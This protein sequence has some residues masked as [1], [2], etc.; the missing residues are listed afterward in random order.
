MNDTDNEEGNYSRK[1][2]DHLPPPL[3]IDELGWPA[4]LKQWNDAV[5][6]IRLQQMLRYGDI[7]MEDKK[8][9]YLW[10]QKRNIHIPKE[11]FDG[12]LNYP[13]ENENQRQAVEER[14]TVLTE[15]LLKMEAGY[16]DKDRSQY[17]KE[18][19]FELLFNHRRLFY[20]P[21]SLEQITGA[22]ARLNTPLP[23]SYKEFLLASNGFL[24]LNGRLLA[25][26]EIDWLK[27]RD[28]DTMETWWVEGGTPE[29][30]DYTDEEYVSG[31]DNLYGAADMTRVQYL[32]NCLQIGERIN[33]SSA[34]DS[35]WLLNPVTQPILGE[36]EAWTWNP[37]DSEIPRYKNFKEAM[38]HQYRLDVAIAKIYLLDAEAEYKSRD[39]SL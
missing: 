4:F 31:Y 8:S 23:P 21:A 32:E 11:V 14:L 17:G 9:F 35:L 12:G 29:K 24:S 5:I 13:P 10:L 19:N 16:T 22:E 18:Y 20:P 34:Q 15:A 27:I 36:W 37:S 38:E 1:I 33:I 25:V 28:K 26:D 2:K 7:S 6:V 3:S 39:S 30:D